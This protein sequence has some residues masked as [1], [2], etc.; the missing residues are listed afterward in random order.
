M[1]AVHL[2]TL[3]GLFGHA[4]AASEY[5]LHSFMVRGEYAVDESAG[6]HQLKDLRFAIGI[7]EHY[8]ALDF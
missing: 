2:D 4:Q 3:M 8:A 5:R 6:S 7:Q 1:S